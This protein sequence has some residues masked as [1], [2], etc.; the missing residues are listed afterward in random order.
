MV[1]ISGWGPNLKYNPYITWPPPHA[2]K[3]L[4]E[5]VVRGGQGEVGRCSPAPNS[6]ALKSWYFPKI[7]GPQNRHQNSIIC[8]LR[9]LQKSTHNFGKLPFGSHGI[10]LL[11]RGVGPP[12]VLEGWK[13]PQAG[14]APYS[15]PPKI[16]SIGTPKM[17]HLILG[18]F[19]KN[20]I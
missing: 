14:S 2:Q 17:V 15:V 3:F 11:L 1:A 4:A 19:Q 8:I 5:V 6:Q 13:C 20:H 9:T 16:L 7:W 10:S 12:R 18:N